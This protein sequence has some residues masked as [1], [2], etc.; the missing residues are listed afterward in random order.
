M[1]YFRIDSSRYGRWSESE[2]EEEL[3]GIEL[4]PWREP[5]YEIDD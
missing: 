3:E 4:P 5:R 1:T 2:K